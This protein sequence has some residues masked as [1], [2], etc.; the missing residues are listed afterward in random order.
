MKSFGTVAAAI[1]ASL[2]PDIL[3]AKRFD[4]EL[5]ITLAS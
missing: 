2:T 4:K 5:W 1:V 3:R